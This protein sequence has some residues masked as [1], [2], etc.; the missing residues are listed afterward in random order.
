[1]KMKEIEKKFKYIIQIRILII[2]KKKNKKIN[3][4]N[5]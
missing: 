2:Q 4:S 5:K 1:M 3:K